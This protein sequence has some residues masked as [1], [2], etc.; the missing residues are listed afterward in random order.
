MKLLYYLFSF[1]LLSLVSPVMAENTTLLT[2]TIS[3]DMNNSIITGDINNDM[4]SSTITGEINTEAPGDFTV[5]VP[6]T[7]A[8]VA[9][10]SVDPK[11]CQ[12]SCN[13]GYTL[14]GSS[15]NAANK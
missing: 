11:T 10:G 14:N 3:N 1:G 6:C 2:G 5:L 12:I 7:P 15:C 9:N 13:N 4:N 8:S